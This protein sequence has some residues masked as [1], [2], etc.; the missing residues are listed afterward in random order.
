MRIQRNI[1]WINIGDVTYSMESRCPGDIDNSWREIL[2]IHPG[3][4]SKRLWYC[5]LA[6]SKNSFGFIAHSL[7][8][9][10]EFVEDFY[11][12]WFCEQIQYF[13]RYPDLVF[14]IDDNKIISEVNSN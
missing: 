9:A 14:E 12:S 7:D 5:D 1:R 10:K 8:E 11:S 3:L 13:D 2:R 4:L 6:E